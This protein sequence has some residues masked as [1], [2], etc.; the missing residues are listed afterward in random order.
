MKKWGRRKLEDLWRLSDKRVQE[1]D[2]GDME[3]LAGDSTMVDTVQRSTDPLS[4][5]TYTQDIPLTDEQMLVSNKKIANALYKL[6]FL[7]KEEL[8][9]NMKAIESFESFVSRFE[10]D[11]RLPGVLYQLYLIYGTNQ[12][13]ASQNKQKDI[14]V[15]QHPESDYAK[16][17]IDPN[18]F[19]ELY[20]E[21]NRAK[22]LY[23]DV[24]QAYLDEQ[25]FSAIIYADDAIATYKQDPLI[26]KF[27]YIKAL[28]KG[29][30]EG[31]DTLV[32]QLR[33][34]VRRF[35]TSEATPMARD[36]LA[37]FNVEAEL[38]QEEKI[39]IQEEKNI[40]EALSVFT[41]NPSTTHYYVMIVPNG[42][43]NTNATKVR[44]S[45]HNIKNYRFQKLKVSSLI[46]DNTR[47]M[48]TVS[49][50]ENEEKAMEYFNDMKSNNYVFAN[51][52]PDS[53]E[54]FVVSSNNY[55]I[56]YQKKDIEMYKRFFR[57]QYLK[58]DK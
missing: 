14:L 29:K 33:Q 49:G 58:E 22:R 1:F 35:P 34:Y 31:D 32:D 3:E 25:Y 56:F 12:D 37:R 42:S 15:G 10:E 13:L 9:D 7:Y 47:E 26:P 53:F 16:L 44:F 36:I 41:Y 18:Y 52:A 4:P 48:I 40:N 6:G 54:H 30:M 17:I 45:D 28:S 51:I 19:A 43:I 11:E 50:L 23:Y 39:E 2:F 21:Q 8:E 20:E 55:P 5:K 24:Y 38:S 57:I 27:E 46:L